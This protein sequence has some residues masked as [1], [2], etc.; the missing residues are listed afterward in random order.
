MKSLLFCLEKLL[1]KRWIFWFLVLLYSEKKIPLTL[2][3]TSHLS[4]TEDHW[5]F[6]LLVWNKTKKSTF[7]FLHE[8]YNL[9]VWREALYNIFF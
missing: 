3:L 5:S 6:K 4:R 9:I 7:F 1:Y 8:E 2:Q